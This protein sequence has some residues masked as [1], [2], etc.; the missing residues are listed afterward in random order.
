MILN[1]V[2]HERCNLTT[3]DREKN[4]NG[5]ECQSIHNRSASHNDSHQLRFVVNQLATKLSQMHLY[6]NNLRNID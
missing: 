3:K 4:I 5:L 2:Y 1:Y 6:P